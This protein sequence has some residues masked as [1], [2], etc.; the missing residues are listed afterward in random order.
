MM[1]KLRNV[2]LILNFNLRIIFS[3]TYDTKLRNV[4]LILNFI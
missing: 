1:Q 3:Q 2:I 4:I